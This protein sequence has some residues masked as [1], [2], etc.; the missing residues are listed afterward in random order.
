VVE[1]GAGGAW[2]RFRLGGFGEVDLAEFQ[3]ARPGNNVTG[4]HG[5]HSDP[6]LSPGST[7][8]A[9]ITIQRKIYRS[10]GYQSAEEA[11]QAYA[12]AY[13]RQYNRHYEG[14]KPFHLTR[15]DKGGMYQPI[16]ITSTGNAL[17]D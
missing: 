13:H 14:Q 3:S 15:T 6:S 12:R 7:Y 16:S 1:Q 8:V 10:L 4:Y 2:G 17:G 9:Q 5:V 11:A